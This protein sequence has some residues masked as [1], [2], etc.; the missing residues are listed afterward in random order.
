MTARKA[1][2]SGSINFGIISIPVKLYS[3]VEDGSSIKFRQ[4]NADTKNP[5]KMKK[6]DSVTG[7]DVKDTV[8]GYEI[9]KGEFVVVTDDEIADLLPDKNSTIE[10]MTFLDEDEIESVYI[11]KP[12]YLGTDGAEKPYR[13]LEQ[14]LRNKK[15]IGIGK[16]VMRSKEYLCIIKPEKD[17]GLS[18]STLRWKNQVRSNYEIAPK[19]V[20]LSEAEIA[21]A[22]NLI[23]AMISD[24]DISEIEETYTEELKALIEDKAAG[25]IVAQPVAKKK[26]EKTD[27]VMAALQASLEIAQQKSS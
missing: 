26:E 5:I 4:L 15:K 8:K 11:E 12:Y 27:D 3:A 10:L 23:E 19:E 6:V 7:A 20:E 25:K 2:W 16:V 1:T 18:V 24:I 13:L 14:A 22:E 21:L 9:S 17:S